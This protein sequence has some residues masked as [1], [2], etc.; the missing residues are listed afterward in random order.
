MDSSATKI[1]VGQQVQQPA[2]A[3]AG[4]NGF[5]AISPVQHAHIAKAL[6][7]CHEPCIH[8]RIGVRRVN[9]R[10]RTRGVQGQGQPPCVQAVEMRRKDDGGR[11]AFQ[12]V[13]GTLQLDALQHHIA[14]RKPQPTAVQPGLAKHHKGLARPGPALCQRGLRKAQLQIAQR[15]AAARRGQHIQHLP[16][17]PAHSAQCRQRQA[18]QHPHQPHPKAAAHATPPAGASAR[19]RL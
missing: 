18:R 13:H 7:P 14:R 4:N 17:Q 15:H 5:H 12:L 2:L 1:H 16:N 3:Q 11:I 19:G 10:E 6:A 8:R 9:G